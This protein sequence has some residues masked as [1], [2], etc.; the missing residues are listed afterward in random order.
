MPDGRTSEDRP[1]IQVA[2]HAGR[3]IEVSMHIKGLCRVLDGAQRRQWGS[4]RGGRYVEEG[5][6]EQAKVEDF[7]LQL[8]CPH[9]FVLPHARAHFSVFAYQYMQGR[10]CEV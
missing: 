10:A 9:H 1:T 3:V 8:L 5:I 7:G 6:E 4:R 2:E